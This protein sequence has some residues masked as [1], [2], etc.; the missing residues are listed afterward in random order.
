MKVDTVDFSAIKSVELSFPEIR[1]ATGYT[2][3]FDMYFD[4]LYLDGTIWNGG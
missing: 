2:E 4:N 1:S 3:E